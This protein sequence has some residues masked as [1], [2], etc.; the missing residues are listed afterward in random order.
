MS[1]LPWFKFYCKDWFL[2]TRDL[3]DR[4]KGCYIDILAG[5]YN[6]GGPL[7]YDE[8]FLSRL[9][10]YGNVRS[11]RTVLGELIEAG[12]LRIED[13]PDGLNL[14]NGRAMEEIDKANK[15]TA[16][17]SGGGKS[18]AARNGAEMGA[19]WAQNQAET[20][21]GFIKKQPLNPC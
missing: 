14:V 15:K 12:K 16:E 21:A 17:R 5:L 20:E 7:P 19:K 4:A 13:S 2:D 10:G 9:C 11:L 8:E 3:S 18:K 6:R 1:G